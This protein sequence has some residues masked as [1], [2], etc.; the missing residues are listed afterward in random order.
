MSGSTGLTVTDLGVAFG[1][2]QAVN[3]VSLEAPLGQITGLI[4]PNG[5]GKTTMFN[6]CSGLLRPTSGR[7]EVLGRDVSRWTPARR[8]RH[9]LGR[10]FQRMELVRTMPVRTNVALGA[11]CRRVGSSPLRQV[12][13][14]PGEHRGMAEA[15][16]A[17]IE[18]CGLTA[19]ADRPVGAL[20]TGQCRLVELAR[21]LAGGFSVLLL[22]EPSS[23]LDEEESARF[24]RI[25]ER[26]V[27]ERGTGILL[28]EHDMSLVMSVCQ[29]VYVL[30]FGMI[31]FDGTPAACQA[32]PDV[33]AAYLGAEAEPAR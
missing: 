23:G 31:I 13:T 20:S 18:L 10:T 1:G 22:D 28:V 30:E 33:R 21:A 25:L 17:A 2:N 9:G 15:A 7:I 26:V 29:H 5:A 14:T 27:A 4:G 11:E 3:G 19:L 16:E 24:G 12:F 32:S 6:A 8:A